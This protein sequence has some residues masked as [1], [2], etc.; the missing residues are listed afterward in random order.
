MRI[1]IFGGTFDPVHHGH[2]IIAEAAREQARLDE[3]WFVPAARP[4]HKLGQSLTPFDRRVDMLRLAIA[5]EPAFRVDE[6]EKD[7]P[8][9]SYTVDTLEEFHRRSPG[10]EWFLIL[11][12]DALADLPGWRRP[13]RI[14]EL[15]A[16]LMFDRPPGGGEGLGGMCD[17]ERARD[18]LTLRVQTISAPLIGIASRDLRSAVNAGRS[19]R[20]QVPRAVEAYIADKGLYL[21]V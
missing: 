15:A 6:T 19:I 5:G 17:P 10:N 20:Y 3:V 18:T 11:G 8:G 13:D 9:P 2:L 21:P 1:G 12:G 7:R 14:A 4:P 16:L